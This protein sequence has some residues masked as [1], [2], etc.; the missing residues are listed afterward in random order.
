MLVMRL[1]G[2]RK[3]RPNR[4]DVFIRRVLRLGYFT[5]SCKVCGWFEVTVFR[6]RDE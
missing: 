2:R 1:V 6:Y 5:K 4:V 3:L